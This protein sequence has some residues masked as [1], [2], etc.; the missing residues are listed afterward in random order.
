M[1]TLKHRRYLGRLLKNARS[2]VQKLKF[3]LVEGFHRVSGEIYNSIS[4]D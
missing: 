3:G 2:L 4:L 1:G